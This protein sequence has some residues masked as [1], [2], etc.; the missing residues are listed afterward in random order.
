EDLVARIV[1]R[2]EAE[3]LRL[4]AH[5]DVFRHQDHLALRLALLQVA[6]D[7]QDLVVGL[8]RG[9]RGRQVTVDRFGLQIEPAAGNRPG[10]RLDRDSG[11]DV[12]DRVRYD[13]VEEP[14]RLPG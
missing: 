12:G 11:G 2:G 1:F 6:H 14:A 13:L 10:L 4:D 8:A 5:V 7:R 3:R 9:E